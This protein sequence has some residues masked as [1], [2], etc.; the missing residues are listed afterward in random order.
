LD[1]AVMVQGKPVFAAGAPVSVRVVA[2]NRG[3]THSAPAYLRLRAASIN[4]R[5]KTIPIESSSV[6]AKAG[7]RRSSQEVSGA[8]TQQSFSSASAAPGA[9][10]PVQFGAGRRLT[11]RFTAPLVL[12]R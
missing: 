1:E 3:A 8:I 4:W 11:F 9:Q 12:P 6:F 10:K 2:L 5:G 7:V